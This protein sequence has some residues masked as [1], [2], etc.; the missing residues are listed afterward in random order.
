MSIFPL[1]RMPMGINS[2][3]G[4]RRYLRARKPSLFGYANSTPSP[5]TPPPYPLLEHPAR[6]H[7]LTLPS[8][9]NQSLPE[10]VAGSILG[11]NPSAYLGTSDPN[12]KSSTESTYLLIYES[13]SLDPW[14]R[15]AV[16]IIK[17][18]LYREGVS[19]VSGRCG[20]FWASTL[21]LDADY[22]FMMAGGVGQLEASSDCG[23]DKGHFFSAFR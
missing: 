12:M 16:E 11:P 3:R 22:L 23:C 1:F 4:V 21:G 20:R 6:L 9:H 17:S 10:L 13:N 14:Q 15:L 8:D 19:Y 5:V 7:L 2:V 18:G